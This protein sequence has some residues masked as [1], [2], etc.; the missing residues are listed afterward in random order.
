MPRIRAVPRDSRTL[1]GGISQACCDMSCVEAVCWQKSCNW[2][3][4]KSGGLASVACAL[5]STAASKS[6]PCL[7][8]LRFLLDYGCCFKLA[9]GMVL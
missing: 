7:C 2:S 9:V 6:L 8:S 4:H 1:G 5:L 3:M